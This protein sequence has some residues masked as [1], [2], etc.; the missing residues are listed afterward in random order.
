MKRLGIILV[1][2][3]L[4]VDL[5]GQ[6]GLPNVLQTYRHLPYLSPALAGVNDFVDINAGHGIQPLSSGQSFGSNLFSAYYSTRKQ[7]RGKNNSFR[8]SGTE[9]QDDFYANKHTQ[10]KLKI[11]FGT[12]FYSEGIGEFNNTY[13]S[14]TV[15]VHVPVADHTYVS[16]GLATG[17]NITRVD[18]ADLLVRQP[19]DP[20]YQIYQ[21]SAGSN[22]YLHIDAGLGLTSIKYYFA[23]GINNIANQRISGDDALDFKNPLVSNLVGGYRFFHSHNFEAIA[24]STVTLQ[25]NGEPTL[26]NFGVRGRINEQVMVGVNLTSDFSIMTQLAFQ[27]NDI[28]NFGYTFSTTTG[29]SVISNSHEIG[30]G[31]R[32]L[33]SGNYSPLW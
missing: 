32:F 21:N 6:E 20:V 11:G 5:F 33:N 18:L 2:I 28:L 10:A 25:S 9:T 29:T 30:I 26:W 8:G 22:T 24:V 7:S 3:A 31:L 1:M 12:A 16:L 27:V 13:N 15:A 23:I 17:F 19:N 14:N 4:Q